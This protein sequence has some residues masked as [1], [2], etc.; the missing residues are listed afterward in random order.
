[1]ILTGEHEGPRLPTDLSDIFFKAGGSL[2]EFRTVG[3]Q[4][5]R[6]MPQFRNYLERKGRDFDL[7][8]LH[9]SYQYPT[10]AAAHFC[11]DA[12]I[13]YVF[14]PHG[15]LDPAVRIKHQFRNRVVDFIYHDRV[16]KNASAWHF[17]SEE[18]RAACERPIWTSSFVEPLGIDIERIPREGPVGN[19]RAKYGIPKE[20]ILLLFLSRI[21]RK[22]V[23]TSC[24]K[25]SGVWSQA[26][27]I[28]FLHCAARLTRTCAG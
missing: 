16:I 23:S 17:T 9:G 19:F 28:S 1:M 14:T 11:Q 25:P 15:S 21:T 7:Y 2:S 3:P 26:F 6:Y 10:Y 8:V 18:E 12:K 20:A 13:P 5:I 24:S 22:K 27:R 4:K